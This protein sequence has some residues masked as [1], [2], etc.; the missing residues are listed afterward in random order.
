MLI[1]GR[2]LFEG[3]HIS[4]GMAT[5]LPCQDQ[6]LSR[7]VAIKIMPGAANERRIRDEVSALLK[8]RSKHVV[9]IYDIFPAENDSLAI[10]QEFISG[11]DLFNDRLFPRTKEEYLRLLWQIAFG[12]AD[13]HD[14]KIIHR[15]IKPN[16]MMVDAEGV[17]KIFDFGLARD[18]GD[19]ANTMGFVGTPGFAA[20]ELYADNPKFTAAVDVYAFGATALY[21]A[22]GD[23]P[24]ELKYRPPK[25]EAKDFFEKLRFGLRDELRNLLNHCLRESPNDRPRMK[26][27]RDVI[28]KNILHETHRALVVFD[29][30]STFLNK[31]N[32]SVSL[33]AKGLGQIKIQYD[34]FDFRAVEVLGEVFINNR[35][36]NNNIA[37]P[38]ACVVALGAPEKK[39][40]R[41][42]I[43]FDLSNP[44]IV[45]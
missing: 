28:A 45:L 15:D 4:G 40:L 27:I 20:P 16:N 42:Y 33:S 34:G 6:V 11:F 9:Q 38:G 24:N 35:A 8:M 2:Y 19:G 37:I 22:M 41:K 12:L 44:E 39:N 1:A 26:E 31:K 10:V 5:V 29:G 7:K 18:E 36:V 14:L 23:L 43:T 17:L 32:R 21:L 25:I 13:I 30:K 3:N